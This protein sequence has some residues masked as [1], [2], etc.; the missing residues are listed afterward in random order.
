MPAAR[1]V[2]GKAGHF[3]FPVDEDHLKDKWDKSQPHALSIRAAAVAA[4]FGANPPY[5][6]LDERKALAA[7]GLTV[8]PSLTPAG[9]AAFLDGRRLLPRTWV[10][11]TP[12]CGGENH[13]DQQANRP[14]PAAGAPVTCRPPDRPS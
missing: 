9:A 3:L 5:L 8:A 1:G 12:F 14:P 10:C 7:L 13:H 2:G 6:V 11:L 4:A